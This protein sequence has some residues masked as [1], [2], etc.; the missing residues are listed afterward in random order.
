MFLK[1][2]E[3][4]IGLV[5]FLILVVLTLLTGIS[6]YYVMLHQTESILSRSLESSLKNAVYIF[7]RQIAQGVSDREMIASRPF[8]IDNLKQI[9]TSSGIAKGKINLQRIAAS[10]LSHG[11]RGVAFY[12]NEGRQVAR[13]GHFS[14]HPN[15]QVPLKEKYS[16]FL[17]WDGQFI[18][19]ARID[20]LDYNGN[21]IGSVMTESELRMLKDAF[22]NLG[23]IGKTGEFAMCAPLEADPKDMSCFFYRMAG[24]EFERLPR[25]I[26]GKALPMD[27]ALE[28]KTG[29][30][31]TRDYRHQKVVAAYAPVGKFGL[32][33][34]LKIDQKELYGPI[35]EQLKDIAAILTALVVLG[36]LLL[37][38]RVTP[39]VRQLF[40]SRRDLLASKQALQKENE[41]NQALL[42][43][44]S[45]GI[46]I[47]DTQGNIVEVS[48]SFCDML[49]YRREEMIGMNVSQ[50]EAG[51][52]E[53]DIAAA[54]RKQFATQEHALFETRHRRKDG[55]AFDVEV[56]GFPLQLQGRLVLFNSSRD[57]TERRQAESL[58]RMQS[59]A[60]SSSTNGVAIADATEPDLPLVYVNPAFEEITGYPASE[61]LG[62]NCRFL[63]GEDRTQPGLTEIRACL[64]EGRPGK[65]MLRNYRK[66][67]SLFWNRIK[68]SPLR[69]K[70][71]KLTH[72]VGIIN[73]VTER[74]HADDHLR[75]VSSVFHYA[76][77]GILITDKEASIL[78]VNPAFSRITGYEHEEV[79]GKTPRILHSGRQDQEFYDAMWRTILESGHWSG[80]VWNKRKNGEIYPQRLTLSAVKND[81]G[82]TIRYIALFS[83]ISNLKNQQQQLE[84]MAHHDALTGLPNRALLN[85][86]LDMALAQAKRS[87]GKLAACFI[88]LDGFKPVNDTFGHEAGDQLLIEVGQ[89]MLAISRATDTVARLGGDEFVLIFQDISDESEFRK[90]LSRIMDSINQAFHIN[91]HD[92]R[93]SAS[94]G[95]AFYTDEADGDNLLR[96]ADQA[97]YIAKQA[98]RN[99]FH[100]F[101]ALQK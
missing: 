47:L 66:D 13:A 97:M 87:G 42:R 85:D 17:I 21:K 29:L 39:L 44:A 80:E 55:S 86:R 92:I 84:R 1:L 67:G 37:Y 89:R 2:E 64:K 16:L 43:N 20:I 88:D 22:D 50:W 71:G 12:D 4:R 70:L 9:K 72:F 8:I 60:L 98:G 63:Q 3:Y 56:S 6:V 82:E 61:L 51:L 46:H 100:F 74:K 58:I 54:L 69:D 25:V 101:D 11:F 27:Y 96:H 40:D 32:G 95:V 83:D 49:G 19:H 65:A 90:M 15:F 53:A 52:S 7:D 5:G 18:L 41:K 77:E 59:D 76:N 10:F 38:W 57:I 30:I 35:T 93:I 45:D 78:E 26:E 94:I 36:G 48:D 99:R 24:R 62:R 79:L 75:L 28:G 81:E 23:S 91:G 33:M 68:I 31:F 73:D 34:V 14:Q